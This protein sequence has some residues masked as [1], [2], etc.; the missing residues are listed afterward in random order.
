MMEQLDK[1][2]A[3]LSKIDASVVVFDDHFAINS[4]TRS[5]HRSFYCL[6][7]ERMAIEKSLPTTL[8]SS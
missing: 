2:P 4:S 8:L 7:G 5:H 6:E 3:D 1:M